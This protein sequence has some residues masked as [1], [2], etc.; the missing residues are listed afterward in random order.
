MFYKFCLVLL[1]YTCTEDLWIK[2]NYFC[3]KLHWHACHVKQSNWIP[4][5][6]GRNCHQLGKERVRDRG[7]GGEKIGKTID[8]VTQVT[9]QKSTRHNAH[10]QKWLSHTSAMK[11]GLFAPF[12]CKMWLQ[13]TKR[14]SLCT[15]MFLWLTK[16][17]SAIASQNRN[18]LKT[19]KIFRILFLQ[20]TLTSN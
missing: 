20:Y 7:M 6:E 11:R 1:V 15:S 17:Y 18:I 10:V 13:L 4:Q 2:V 5:N 14:L 8:Y 3:A 16:K 9:K 19:S 12:S